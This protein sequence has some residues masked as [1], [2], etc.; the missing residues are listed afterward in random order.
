MIP[1]ANLSLIVALYYSLALAYEISPATNLEGLREI[2]QHITV[3]LN[4]RGA[5]EF[6]V[7]AK[8]VVK[9]IQTELANAGLPAKKSE[10]GL[11]K[12]NVNVSGESVGGGVATYTVE[13]VLHLRVPSPFIEDR[14]IDAIVWR[15]KK[16]DNLALHDPL[17]LFVKGPINQRVYDSVREV[18]ARLISDFKK[19]N[20][21]K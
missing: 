21:G 14:T 11:P 4:L 17:G 8:K 3:S 19:A 10:P 13:M 18:V 12:L 5:E 16:T 6:N 1:L 9:I 15:E 2:H 7:Y 20:P